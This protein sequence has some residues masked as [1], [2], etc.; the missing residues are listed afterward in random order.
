MLRLTGARFA[1][2]LIGISIGSLVGAGLARATDISQ[3]PLF[4]VSAVKPNVMFLMDDS[5][6]MKRKFLPDDST[7]WGYEHQYGYWSAQC[8]HMAYNPSYRYV[9][10]VRAD[11]TTE[12]N[13]DLSGFGTQFY[14]RYTAAG[15]Q[16]AMNFEFDAQDRIVQN[17]FYYECNSAIGNAPGSA[18]FERVEITTSS[19]DGEAQNYANWKRY[20]QARREM[21]KTAIKQVFNR[22]DSNYRVGFSVT[23]NP[24]AFDQSTNPWYQTWG[25]LDVRDF[26][27]AQKSRFFRAIDRSDNEHET[28]L[29]GALSKTGQYFANK[30]YEQSYDPMQRY[31]QRN[32]AILATDGGWTR[33]GEYAHF[34]PLNLEKKDIG[35]QDEADSVLPPLRGAGKDQVTTLADVA[36]YYYGTDL[37][38]PMLQNCTGSL[39]TDVC[40]NK[41]P[42]QEGDAYQSY[43]DLASWQH[44]TLFTVGLG[45][46]GTIKYRDD[47][48]TAREGDFHEIVM[49]NK[50]WPGLADP[51]TQNDTMPRSH[52]D[53]M[54][55]AAV[56]GR[57]RHF[58]ANDPVSL[59]RSL[60]TALDLVRAASGAGAAASTSN[61]QP[62]QDDNDVFFAKFTSQ[63][64]IGDVLAY[65]INPV[66]GAILP[67]VT[68][69]AKEQLDRPSVTPANRKI[70]YRRP[71]SQPGDTLRE[72][73]AGNLKADN[74]DKSFDKF[75]TKKGAGQ[76]TRPEQCTW[77][78]G[79]SLSAA[80]DIENMI[81]YL[82]GEQGLTYYRA[83]ESRLGDIVNASPAFVGRPAFPYTDPSYLQYVS[84]KE[85]RAPA[86]VLVGAND[87]M[88]H[89]FD[90]TSGAE[91]W[92]Y[93]P[94]FVMPNLY[95]LADTNYPNNHSFFVDGSPRVADIKVGSEWRTI[96]VGGL[97]A[98]GRG[99][100]ALDV[101]DPANPKTL[102]E[103]AHDDLGLSFGNPVV[104]QISKP[105]K[106]WVVVFGSGYNNVSPGSGKGHLFVL[107]A[108]TGEL[109][110]Q[111]SAVGANSDGIAKVNAW[112]D[113][114][115]QNVA[116]RFYGGDLQG[117]L[118]RFD[119]DDQVLPSGD[120]AHLL[121]E[122]KDANG[123][124]QPITA[125]PTLAELRI[126]GNLYPVVYVATGRYLG[127][128]DIPDSSPQSLYAIKDPLSSEKLGNVRSRADMVHQTVSVTTEASTGRV[129]RQVSSTDVDWS[130][131]AGWF[132][133]FPEGG[134]R[135]MVD[136]S[137]ALD[138]L[139][140]AANVP[141]PDTC[142]SGGTAY[143]YELGL[144]S[145]SG[146][147]TWGVDSLILG[148]TTLRRQDGSLDRLMTRADGRLETMPGTPTTAMAN[149]RRVSW[150][151]IVD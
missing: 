138:K 10:P 28:P 150:R 42:T 148:L 127:F 131:K 38:S 22:L 94:S 18:V 137:I 134:E 41:V 143:M 12:P 13:A 51:G 29:R 33:S 121:A 74:L 45:L 7:R 104:T 113:D 76:S 87:G 96:V 8:N 112:V 66:T 46:S 83:R 77:L 82:R 106:Q 53:D 65:K 49:R 109:K 11:G 132:L 128:G 114:D 124:A 149:L 142:L 145:G 54:W 1:A 16:P 140:V 84:E 118:W 21:A 56:N 86:L 85:S 70:L 67:Q 14:Y 107:D 129:G 25:F 133:D 117:N 50:N 44:V 122:L 136:M 52:T 39:G 103:F 36:A 146:S 27:D 79:D 3:S 95:K 98:G 43:G 119:I 130:T 9:P 81:S 80:N 61:P 78:A 60:S 90:R 99:Y 17:Q 37:R 91:V 58:S 100:Y 63:K 15:K 120:E 73:T 4:M 101:T 69:S 123:K 2:Y 48:T 30:A 88:L 24:S 89:A 92:A 147:S 151:E 126:N 93:V 116:S 72:F 55:H 139:Y 64:W 34:G 57:G 111:L 23:S 6:S 26:D 32:Y 68:W 125:K 31:C 144:E 47:Y 5:G 19:P 135:V 110:K 141:A 59:V 75:C 20:Y 108:A 115:S 40:Q 35:Q 71:D 62:V 97:N 105:T 102:W